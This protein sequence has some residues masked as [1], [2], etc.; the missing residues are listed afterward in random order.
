M[1]ARFTLTA[2]A[3]RVSELFDIEFTAELAPRF[4]IAPTQ[5]VLAMRLNEQAQRDCVRLR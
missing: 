2:N 4:N 1:C 3:N 5:N